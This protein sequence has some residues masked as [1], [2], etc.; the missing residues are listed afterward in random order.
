M[1]GPATHKAVRPA[2]RRTEEYEPEGGRG[3]APPVIARRHGSMII[4]MP[5]ARDICWMLV[6][7]FSRRARREAPTFDANMRAAAIAAKATSMEAML[8]ASQ[9]SC[10][11]Y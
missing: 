10:N 7:L 11:I 9:D 4:M 8:G 1:L 3:R 2:I 5:E 6:V